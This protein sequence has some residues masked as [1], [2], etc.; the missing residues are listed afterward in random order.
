MSDMLYRSLDKA[1]QKDGFSISE[2]I[3]LSSIQEISEEDNHNG[4]IYILR[5]KNNRLSK[6]KNLYKI[7]C[8]TSA[9]SDRIKNA[10]KEATYL[11]SEVEIV[12]ALRCYNIIPDEL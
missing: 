8:T 3:E 2:P 12:K 6:Y 9:V 10:H 7:G 11:F 4:Y 1:L 5:T